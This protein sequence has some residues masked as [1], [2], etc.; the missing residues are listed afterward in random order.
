VDRENIDD[1]ERRSKQREK[2]LQLWAKKYAERQN[3]CNFVGKSMW[4]AKMRTVQY[5]RVCEFT[6]Y[7]V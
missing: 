2:Y 5:L 6:Q 7:N 1:S 4:A 3:I